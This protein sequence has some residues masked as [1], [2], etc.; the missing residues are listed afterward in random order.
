MKST[1]ILTFNLDINKY[2]D[3]ITMKGYCSNVIVELPDSSKYKVSFYDPVRLS[4]DLENEKYIAEPGLIIIK[5]LTIKEM[6]YAVNQLWQDEFFN[7]LKSVT[8]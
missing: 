2:E 8:G 4:Q 6:Q 7:Q 1:P 5:R 3:E